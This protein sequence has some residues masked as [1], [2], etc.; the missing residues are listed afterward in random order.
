MLVTGKLL[1]IEHLVIAMK[2]YVISWS[3][4]RDLLASLVNAV[5]N[6][7]IAGRDVKEH[8]VLH[9]SHV[10]SSRIP[11]IIQAYDNALLIKD[12]KRKRND[13]VHRGSIPDDDIE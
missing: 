9:N 12:L 4:L 3:T 8:L 2:L 7:G 13:V 5:F 11:Q 6:L 10:K 1:T